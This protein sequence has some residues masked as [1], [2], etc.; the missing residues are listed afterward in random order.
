MH[1]VW[2]FFRVGRKGNQTERDHAP[3]RPEVT[4]GKLQEKGVGKHPS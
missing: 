2:D 3:P 4:V 1:V